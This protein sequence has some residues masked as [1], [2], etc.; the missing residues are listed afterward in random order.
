M[1]EHP[2]HTTP[3]DTSGLV[4]EILTVLAEEEPH[5]ATAA[6]V[7]LVMGV[8]FNDVLMQDVLEELVERSILDRRGIDVGA[9]YT[10][11][12]GI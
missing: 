11:A 2:D 10:L 4:D 5:G 3:A 12:A 9:V 7:A 1:G 8:G 6:H